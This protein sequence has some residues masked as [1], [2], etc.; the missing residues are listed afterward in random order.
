MVKGGQVLF[1]SQ[2]YFISSWKKA[3]NYSLLWVLHQKIT[4]YIKFHHSFTFSCYS[5]LLQIIHAKGCMYESARYVTIASNN[6]L[7]PAWHQTAIYYNIIDFD[8]IW[9]KIQHF[10]CMKVKL[11][12]S[13]GFR[14]FLSTIL[15]VSMCETFCWSGA[16][17]K[18]KMLSYLHRNSNHSDKMVSRLFHLYNG[19]PSL[20]WWHLYTESVHRT[21]T[22]P[23]AM[24]L[25]S[26]P[27][28]GFLMPAS[29]NTKEST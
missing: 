7:S 21:T 18:V 26:L 11:K 1:F 22:F 12:M 15:S 25:V 13:S 28:N 5:D 16:Q 20:I 2:R 29:P 27:V 14:P 6:Y 9:I 17:F 23:I 4:I 24:P 10:S 8:V 19:N 3:M